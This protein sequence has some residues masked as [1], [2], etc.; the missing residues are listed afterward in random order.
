[1]SE[2]KKI[3][4]GLL[5]GGRS[6]EHEVSIAS[7]LSVYNAL[8]KSRYEVTLIGIDKQGRWLLPDPQAM[9]AQA[10]DPMHA[11]IKDNS[12][13]VGLL[14]YASVKQM[15]PVE[16]R[17]TKI[18]HVDVMLPILHGTYGED[19]TMQGLLEL[20]QIPYTGS[21]VLGSAVGMDKD[22]ARRRLSQRWRA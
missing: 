15:V 2:S 11:K 18:P 4:V 17:E 14:P 21:G 7:A 13:F 3:H 22:V 16:T 12:Q 5:F 10:R 19:G 8:D 9:L 20:A 1:M 6:G